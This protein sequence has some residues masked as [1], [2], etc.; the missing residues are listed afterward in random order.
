MGQ[1]WLH[2]GSPKTGTTSLQGFLSANQE[3]LRT[4]CGVN[5]MSAGRSHIAHNQLATSARMG[6]TG[7]LF[8]KIAAEA[9]ALP[10][11]AHIISS[12]LLFN[13]FTT[14]RLTKVIPDAMKGRTKVICYIRRQDHY[15]EALYKQFLKNGRIPP[16]RQAFLEDAPRVLRY[17]DVL[18][19]YGRAF[20]R[21]NIIVRPF[22]QDRLEGGDVVLDFANLVGLEL[23]SGMTMN[24]VFANKTFSAEMSEALALM[25]K[26]TDFNVREMIRELTS[27]NMPHTIK[28]RDVFT[29]SERRG[30][31]ERLAEENRKLIR[32][33]M[34]DDAAFFNFDDLA[35]DDQEDRAA[36]EDRLRDREAATRAMLT[37]MG[38][39]QR[40]R[41]QEAELAPEAKTHTSTDNDL[42]DRDAPPSWFREIYPAGPR[43][44][45]FRKFG[46]HSCSFVDRGK[47]QLVVS[48]DN[49]SQAGNEAY[50]REPW[51][52]KFCEDRGFSHLG[53]Y[54]QTP[55]WFRQDALIKE[56][57]RI[58]DDGFFKQFDEVAFVGTS[59]GGFAALTFSALS[60]GA[61]VV[62]FSP[63][64]TL[65][66]ALVPWESRFAKGRAADWSL[67][68]SDSA[69]S[70][71]S[72]KQVF[73][74]Y[75]PFHASDKGHIDR[76]T[77]D[78]IVRLKG[79]GL[80]HKSALAL[81]RMEAL[82]PVMEGGIAGTLEPETF[83]QMI[84][85]RK[86]VYLYR[87][88]M[89]GYL[90][91][92]GEDTRR[93]RFAAAFIR[94]RRKLQASTAT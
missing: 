39:L 68:Y 9:D 74:V 50:A 71:Q 58:R 36:L 41:Q 13:P 70:T 48:F 86:D 47:K 85:A 30:L 6:Q 79:F 29:K 87:H 28:S 64:S 31:M 21:E 17:F 37:A 22:S 83:Y 8:D 46:D 25:G 73:V 45:W 63:Q 54:A 88:T 12:E 44:G 14:R 77:G 60:P 26:N 76:L 91:A 92:K 61:R 2:I 5:F 42:E 11:H 4:D 32:R 51:A 53:V 20:G 24:K 65:D 16:D 81:N 3:T 15:L 66:K 56:L 43:D 49:L 52:Q 23:Q 1:I 40:R 80:G 67:P 57:E 59:M 78:N 72:A 90:A 10:N 18:N 62:A 35:S 82:K 7:P 55:S 93:N 69:T 19:A 75:D 89:E 34:P 38:N 84:R 94:R 27:L 33:Y